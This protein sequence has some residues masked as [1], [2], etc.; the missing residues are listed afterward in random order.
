M[1]RE[2]QA[3]LGKI[4]AFKE[5]MLSMVLKSKT[6]QAFM[7]KWVNAKHPKAQFLFAH[8]AGAG[9]ESEFMTSMAQN[10][11]KQGVNV[12]LFDFEYMQQAKANDKKRP[13]DRAP[14]LLAYFEKMLSELDT[15]L[16]I[17]IGG[18]SMGGRMASMLA[19]E[20]EVKGVLAFGYPFHP[21]V[22]LTSY[23]LNISQI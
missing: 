9:M 14:K 18:K 10:L 7:I 4:V 2:S 19:C 20:V 16:P 13:P 12:G 3:E 11:A 15:D 8:G 17:F 6:R 1:L 23:G 21:P 22:N 5:W